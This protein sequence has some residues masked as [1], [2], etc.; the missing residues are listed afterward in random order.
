[1]EIP[2]KLYKYEAFS[3]RSLRNLKRQVI[4]F[5]SPNGFNDPYDCA[6]TA[7][8]H[9]LTDE[10]IELFKKHFLNKKDTPI[11]VKNDLE[12][13][14]RHEIVNI[15]KVVVLES[16]TL[17]R[18]D[19]MSKCGVTCLSEVNDNLLMWSHYGGKYKGFCLEFDAR[20]EPFTKA[21]KVQYSQHM[22]KIEPLP[23]IIEDN[24]KQFM[25]LFCLKSK[26]WDY[27]KEWRVFHN[28]A[29]TLYGY[30]DLALTGV[31]FG[32]DIEQECFEI[33][34]LILGGQNKNVKL[35]RG[36]RSKTAFKVEF[37]EVNYTTYLEA[38]RLGLR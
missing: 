34:G 32:P 1:M 13:K 7:E 19:F 36:N 24:G 17:L 10:Q 20:F 21:R 4:Y 30:P 27:E 16:L 18:D 29:G 22:P 6:I 9:D 15:L 8:M 2:K 3:E 12:K 37:E 25:D 11:K 38:R 35:Y 23:F 5:S 14:S 26:S 31:F 28:E 33:I